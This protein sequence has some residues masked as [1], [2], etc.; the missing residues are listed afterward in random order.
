MRNLIFILLVAFVCSTGALPVR[1]Q[2]GVQKV[3][4]GM[5][6][7]GK[8]GKAL[9]SA[10]QTVRQAG[11]KSSISA[12]SNLSTRARGQVSRVSSLSSTS[13]RTAN[14]RQVQPASV[15]KP[16]ELKISVLA[17]VE[18]RL[19]SYRP[20]VSLL[21][22]MFRAHPGVGGARSDSF[23]GTLLQ[24]EDG[25][26]FGVVATHALAETATELSLKRHFLAE[27]YVDGHFVAVPAEIVVLSAPMMLDVSL[28]K[29]QLTPFQKEFLRPFS[30]SAQPPSPNDLLASHGFVREQATHVPNRYMMSQS[31]VSLRTMMP[32]PQERKG[33]CGGPLVNAQNELVGIHVGST[34]NTTNGGDV[35]FA[36]PV[37]YL[38]LLVQAYQQGHSV[39]YPIMFQGQKIVDLALE[40]YISQ[41]RFFDRK[42]QEIMKSQVENKFS[43]SKFTALM[44]RLSPRKLEITISR[45]ELNELGCLTYSSS[46]RKVVYEVNF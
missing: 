35:G 16:S 17:P 36:T 26:V 31:N 46:T 40:E 10:N 9:S 41:I 27:I 5:S 20:A 7:L 18:E 37:S 44:E 11:A 29:L 23:S 24:L 12:G 38:K 3:I 4:S 25:S 30:L 1:A 34:A 21:R 43:Y 33:L 28:V 19:S 13:V 6:Q 15:L 42:G 22:S 2:G 14:T 32:Y 39:T 8:S 45:A